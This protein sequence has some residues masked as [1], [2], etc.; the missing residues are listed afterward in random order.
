MFKRISAVIGFSLF[1]ILAC[2]PVMAQNNE[3]PY[4]MIK[5][6][7]DKTFARIAA[8]QPLIATDANHLKTIVA[9]KLM[10]YINHRL[11]AKI[12]L[13]R[14]KAS[15]ADKKA[16]YTAFEKYLVTTYATV[17][18]QY[19]NQTVKFEPEKPIDG[20]KLVMVKTRLVSPG[21]DDIKIDFKVRKNSK[22]GQ[23]KAYDLKSHG[24]QPA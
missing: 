1:V 5:Q 14:T 18:A 3:N 21:V 4:R 8:D 13:G 6:V 9:D 22:T 2:T 24:C 16:F 10:P 11:A 23:W 19:S 12:I 17:F 20:K 15:K 7:A